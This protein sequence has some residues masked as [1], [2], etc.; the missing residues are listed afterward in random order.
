MFNYKFSV[1]DKFKFSEKN[2]ENLLKNGG[3]LYPNLENTIKQLSQKYNMT[4]DDIDMIDTAT[5][6]NEGAES[7]IQD[8]KEN[9]DNHLYDAKS[10]DEVEKYEKENEVKIINKKDRF[11]SVFFIMSYFT[12]KAFSVDK[13]E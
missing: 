13:F 8:M 4:Q 6:I 12:I 7:V 10:E 5:T 2:I 3:T 9:I 1:G 11:F